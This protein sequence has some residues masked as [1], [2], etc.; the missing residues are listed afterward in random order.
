MYLDT[1]PAC[2]TL[3]STGDTMDKAIR[4][5]LRKIAQQGGRAGTGKSKIRGGADY[6]RRM[7][8]KSAMAKRAKRAQHLKVT[9]R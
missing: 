7:G 9:A 4:Q 6:Y 3:L 8:L 2:V 1:Q 5:Y